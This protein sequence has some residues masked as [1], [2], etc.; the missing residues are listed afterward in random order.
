MN[1]LYKKLNKY[2]DKALL[3]LVVASVITFILYPFLTV[4]VE[5]FMDNG[6]FSLASFERFFTEDFHLFK[7]SLMV[8]VATTLISSAISLMIAIYASYFGNKKRIENILLLTMISPPF[9]TSLSYIE[10]FGRRGFITHSILGLTLNTYGFWGIVL[11]QSLGFISLNSIILISSIERI[12]E[13]IIH[14]ARD[15]GAKSDSII[16]DHV[17][18]MLTNSFSV[19]L[20]LTFVRSI[21]DFSTPAIIGGNFSTMA[22]ESY[23]SM[24]AY[25]DRAYASAINVILFIP[26]L[27][28]FTFYSQNI[29]KQRNEGKTIANTV[30]LPKNG[31]L[32]YLCLIVTIFF[33][34]ML[35]LNYGAIIFSAFTKNKMGVA[36]F[37]LQNFAISRYAIG[38]TI[39]RSIVY[40]LI[41]A[42]IATFTGM[43]IGYYFSIRK[44]K[45]MEMIDFISMIPYIIPGSFFGIGYILAF[46]NPPLAL[47]GTAAIV[48][49]NMTFKTLP[50]SSKIGVDAASEISDET[51]CSV[52]DLGGGHMNVLFD[53]VFPQSKSFLFTS[54]VNAFTSSMTTIG[55]IIFLVYP[56]QKVAT[57]VMFEVISAGKYKTGSVIAVIIMA[58]TLA[59]NLVSRKL[60]K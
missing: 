2:G 7:N 5:A 18:P 4:F 30:N 55:S 1:T 8:G 31:K 49:L 44:I 41:S 57:M 48:T 56:G 27:I 16:I 6:S 34:G 26:S 38:G 23:L 59:A 29:K 10:L 37:S 9:V 35:M 50:F 60:M 46:K 13:Q 58:M 36:Y 21:A 11:M 51:V 24:I 43:L 25:G 45:L 33:V 53:T 22:T 42:I 12:D 17:L 20:L 28:A 3:F 19:A 32:Y 14:S 52:Y 39:L 40:A 54:F 47:T 15:L